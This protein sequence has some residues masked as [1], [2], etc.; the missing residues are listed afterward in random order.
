[1]IGSDGYEYENITD[2]LLGKPKECRRNKALRSISRSA[3]PEA[4]KAFLEAWDEAAEKGLSDDYARSVACYA[5]V[6]QPSRPGGNGLPAAVPP[7]PAA[8]HPTN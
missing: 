5:L 8:V 1:M 7:P 2:R 6:T 4:R 3:S